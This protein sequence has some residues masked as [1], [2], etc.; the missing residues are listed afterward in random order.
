MAESFEFAGIVFPEFKSLFL[1]LSKV[2]HHLM[3]LKVNIKVI[4][5]FSVVFVGVRATCTAGRIPRL[6]GVTLSDVED[7]LVHR[8][9][10]KTI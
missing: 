6:G 4:A 3:L 5:I 7:A 2:Y 10:H 8:F 9:L 1:E